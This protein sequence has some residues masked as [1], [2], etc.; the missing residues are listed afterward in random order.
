MP[1]F[2]NNELPRLCLA[3]IRRAE[4]PMHVREIARAAL[5]AKHADLMD[6]D[7]WRQPSSGVRDMLGPYHERGLVRIVSI[8]DRRVCGGKFCRTRAE[9]EVICAL[10]FVSLVPKMYRGRLVH[11]DAYLPRQILHRSV[12]L[13]GV[14]E[15][16]L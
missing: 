1:L 7:S 10:G 9:L 13:Q 14:I 6:R 3:I 12:L 5:A 4:A 15:S 11:R 16:A 8:H 2:R